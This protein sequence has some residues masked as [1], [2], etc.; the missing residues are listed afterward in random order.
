[1]VFRLQLMMAGFRLWLGWK[2]PLGPE[3]AVREAPVPGLEGLG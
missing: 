1:V 2:T 3:T